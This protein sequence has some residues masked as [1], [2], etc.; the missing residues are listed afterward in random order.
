MVSPTDLKTILG[1]NP[2]ELE[3]ILGRPLTNVERN[4]ENTLYRSVEGFAE[5]LIVYQTY[6][7]ADERSGIDALS[8]LFNRRKFDS[9]LELA[10]KNVDAALAALEK[11]GTDSKRQG[12][13][14][15]YD[16]SLLMIDIDH[17]KKVNDT[18]G[19]PEGDTLIQRVAECLKGGIREGKG[20]KAYRYGG[21]EFTIILP[22]TSLDIARDVAER[23]RRNVESGCMIQNSVQTISIGAANY[24]EVCKRIED[25]KQYADK[26]LYEAKELGRNRVVVYQKPE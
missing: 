11:R 20:D 12:D 19:H 8:G 10:V 2:T 16:V 3:E 5:R 22:Q 7:L 6:R 4:M 13:A 23:L 25:L 18:Y 24:K 14:S 21:E 9:D 1:R 15:I 17:F 26:A